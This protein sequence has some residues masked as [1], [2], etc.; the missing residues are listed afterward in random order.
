MA[1]Q[2]LDSL[3]SAGQVVARRTEYTGGVLIDLAR[4]IETNQKNNAPYT[5]ELNI[6]C[7]TVSGQDPALGQILPAAIQGGA[8]FTRL[9]QLMAAIT[10]DAVVLPKKEAILLILSRGLMDG[11]AKGQT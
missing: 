3:K 10:P 11:V 6:F 5:A 4:K 7:A 9:T 8:D 1:L 2:T